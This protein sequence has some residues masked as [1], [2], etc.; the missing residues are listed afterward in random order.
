M[1]VRALSTLLVSNVLCLF[2][3]QTSLKVSKLIVLKKETSIILQ[4][5]HTYSD[6]FYVIHYMIVQLSFE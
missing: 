5:N 3:K 6:F 2:A 1:K 4:K